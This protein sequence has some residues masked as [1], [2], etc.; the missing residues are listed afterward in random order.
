[1][2]VPRIGI[3]VRDVLEEPV[4]GAVAGVVLPVV[5]RGRVAAPAPHRQLQLRSEILVGEVHPVDVRAD[6]MAVGAGVDAERRTRE[7]ETDAREHDDDNERAQAGDTANGGHRRTVACGVPEGSRNVGGRAGA[8]DTWGRGVD[9][10]SFRRHDTS[11]FPLAVLGVCARARVSAR[12]LLRVYA[13]GRTARILTG[14]RGWGA[15]SCDA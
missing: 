5:A 15:V 1:M 9:A 13:A 11:A 3:V 4:A 2:R 7:R 10:A 14:M 8:R 6:R 12:R